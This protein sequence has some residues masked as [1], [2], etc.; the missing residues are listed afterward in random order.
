MPLTDLACRRA[1]TV[2]GT[3]VKLA[4]DKGLYLL[5]KSSGRYWRWDYRFGEKR[6]TMA[7]GVYPEVGLAQARADRDKARKLLA[8]GNDP[9]A[10]RKV[11]KLVRVTASGNSFKSVAVE[12]RIQPRDHTLTDA[13]I[14]ALSTKIVAAAE[15][16]GARL[17]S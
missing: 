7:L 15:K 1:K 14:E 5:V 3:S 13:E 12:V 4:D 11:D 8:S 6:K 16:L 9:M 10:D 17:R 2:D